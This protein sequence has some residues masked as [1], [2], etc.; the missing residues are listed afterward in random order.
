MKRTTLLLTLLTAILVSGSGVAWAITNGLPDT[1]DPPKYDRV[2][3]IKDG[4]GF[5][6]S[7]TLVSDTAMLAPQYVLTAA[8]CSPYNTQ[9][10]PDPK[11]PVCISFGAKI[12]DV[13]V[14]KF[15]NGQTNCNPQGSETWYS[16]AFTKSSFYSGSSRDDLGVITLDSQQLTTQPKTPRP[17][18]PTKVGPVQ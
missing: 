9:G 7:G 10:N 2:V 13:S 18:L 14:T 11:Y 1:S 4:M 8:H 5:E 12:A 3:A 6:C 16:G 15:Q 17:K